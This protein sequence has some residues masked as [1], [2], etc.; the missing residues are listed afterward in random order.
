MRTEENIIW[1]EFLMG[2]SKREMGIQSIFCPLSILI[3]PL[4]HQHNL[5]IKGQSL[6]ISLLLKDI[7]IHPGRQLN[8]PGAS[9]FPELMNKTSPYLLPASSLGKELISGAHLQLSEC[10]THLGSS[11]LDPEEIPSLIVESAV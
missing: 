2:M 3:T 5:P 9:P 7:S 6:L 8:P 11:T 1:G 10:Q 4:A